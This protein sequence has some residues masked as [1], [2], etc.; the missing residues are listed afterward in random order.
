[1]LT[2]FM[3]FLFSPSGRVFLL[4]KNFPSLLTDNVVQKAKFLYI[5]LKKKKEQKCFS[6]INMTRC[7]NK[8][9]AYFT[10]LW[11]YKLTVYLSRPCLFSIECHFIVF[12]YFL[13]KKA[14]FATK[15]FETI[16]FYRFIETQSIYKE[17]Y[18]FNVSTICWI[19]S[20]AI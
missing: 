11:V 17:R 2:L 14:I 8:Y 4:F 1:M 3:G 18:I 7:P 13:L 15:G 19:W 9:S 5:L 16:I 10:C 6:H 20:F 12:W